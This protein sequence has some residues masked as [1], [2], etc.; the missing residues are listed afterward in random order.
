MGYWLQYLQWLI[1]RRGAL[2]QLHIASVVSSSYDPFMDHHLQ[3]DWTVVCG[4]VSTPQDDKLILDAP[5]K[6]PKPRSRRHRRDTSNDL[7]DLVVIVMTRTV[8]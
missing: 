3:S 2:F 8:N 1:E 6:Q 5:P 7:L 4:C